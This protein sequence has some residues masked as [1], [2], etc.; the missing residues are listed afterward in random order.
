VTHT[1]LL[2]LLRDI[3][4]SGEPIERDGRFARRCPCCEGIDDR[5]AQ[6]RRFFTERSGHRADC[7]LLLAIQEPREEA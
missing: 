3:E 6:D 1:E 7:R 5:A 2:Q 4:W